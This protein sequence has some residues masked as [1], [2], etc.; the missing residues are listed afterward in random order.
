MKHI[1][2]FWAC[3]CIVV[4]LASCDNNST[5][6]SLENPE[7]TFP[8]TSI[9]LG[10]LDNQM[11]HQGEA[12]FMEKCTQCHKIE[13]KFVGPAL[14]GVTKRRR[15]EWIMNMMLDPLQMI[16]KDPIAKDLLKEFKGAP[17]TN[18]HLTHDEARKIL[19][20]LRTI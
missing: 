5:S 3:C 10:A 11:A 14:K 13:S 17:M 15:P 6:G 9:E 18:Q 16:K 7:S 20:F 1:I 19:E 12:L 2:G 4:M 8:V